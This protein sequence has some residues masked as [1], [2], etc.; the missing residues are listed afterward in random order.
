MGYG[1]RDTHVDVVGI[2]AERPPLGGV[3]VQLHL[4]VKLRELE[5]RIEQQLLA[6]RARGKRARQKNAPSDFP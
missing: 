6:C 3:L 1:G 4:P 2:G 5:I